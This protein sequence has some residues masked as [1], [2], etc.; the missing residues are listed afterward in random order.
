MFSFSS[1]LN[2]DGVFGSDSAERQKGKASG[3]LARSKAQLRQLKEEVR[4]ELAALNE[5]YQPTIQELKREIKAELAA[6]NEECRPTIR[7]V[8]R[9]VRTQLVIIEAKCQPTLQELKEEIR[10]HWV[11]LEQKTR[12]IFRQVKQAI[13]PRLTEFDEKYQQ[14]VQDRIDPLLGNTQRTQ[15]R[16][17]LNGENVKLRREE[18]MANRRLGLG[19]SSLS[20][21][22]MSNIVPPLLPLSIA[23]GILASSAKYPQA[24]RQWKEN[25]KLEAIH[26]ICIYSLYL[27]LGGYASA[28]ALGSVL[29]GLMMKAKAVSE[30]ESRNNLVSLFQLQ[31]DKVWV[32]IDGV[33]IEI[34]FEELQIGDTLVVHAGQTIPVDGTIIAGAA[35]VDQQMLTGEAQPVEKGVGDSV[36]A[37][38]LLISG[39][40]DV[41]VEKTKTETTAGQIASILNRASQNSK[42]A[43]VSAIAAADRYAM[44]TLTASLISMPFIG[45]A[46]AVSLMGANTTTASYLSGSLS[47]L[48]FLNLAARQRI[49][50]KEAGSLEKLHSV[51]A[52]VFDKT[53]TLTI[54]QPHVARIHLFN[55]LD[56]ITIL[57]IAAAAEARQTHPI[58]RAIMTAAS[59][60]GLELPAI[61][62]AHYEM[63]YGIKVR[64]AAAL[65]N[66]VLNQP[67]VRVGSRRFM[68]ME[69][70]AIPPEVDALTADCQAQGHSLV[71]VALNDELVGCLELQPTVRPEAQEVIRHLRERGLKLYIISGD[72]EAPTRKLADDLGMTGY[73]ANVLPEGKASL[74]EQLQK[75][76]HRVCFIGDGIND[77]IAMRQ[78]DVSISLRGATTVATDTAQ[79]ILMEGTLD[80]LQH[81]FE[82]A[83][84]FERNLKLNIRFTSGVSIAAVSGILF[85]G[86]TFYATE[87]FYSVSLLG[88]MGIA[89]KPLL[90]HGVTTKQKTDVAP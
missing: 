25:K 32:R 41:T 30:N 66:S 49:L 10:P 71:M 48:N 6:L 43:S 74:V 28:G 13:G 90:D 17:L 5:E 33:E 82:L 37:S 14:F 60:L 73:F 2:S 54:E 31:P 75:E 26:L 62:E 38:T 35:T 45:P 1:F 34:P 70:I 4:A 46:G 40:V 29:Y 23:I 55:G 78:A 12:P 22:L 58:A 53:G 65:N 16:T 52:I 3:F 83:G 56:E 9:E 79:I 57:T 68:T 7:E 50:V 67:L 51:T 27:W 18:Q 84:E 24:W 42:P 77:A 19:L 76:G 86:F 47:T 63:G 61:D 20:L 59:E 85:A 36:L 11:T 44:P 64:L 81:L 8:K 39:M 87:I 89:L 88:G 15:L 69:S 72:Q 80:Q 21:A